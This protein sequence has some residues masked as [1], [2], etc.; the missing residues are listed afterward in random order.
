VKYCEELIS[1]GKPKGDRGAQLELEVRLMVRPR[2]LRIRVSTRLCNCLAK[3]VAIVALQASLTLGA[4]WGEGARVSLCFPKV[5]PLSS[6]KAVKTCANPGKN[7]PFLPRDREER[8][9]SLRWF[10]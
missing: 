5:N 9:R 1:S 7:C 10:W 6:E 2:V 8:C 4:G 3:V